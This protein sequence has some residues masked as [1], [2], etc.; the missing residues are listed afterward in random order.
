VELCSLHLAYGADPG[1]LVANS[2][3]A[4]GSASVIVGQGAEGGYGAWQLRDFSSC[5]L[6][7]SRDAMTWSIGDHGFE[8]TLSAGVPEIIRRQLSPWCQS[9][10][11]R[12][13]LEISD[14]RGWAIH[15]GGP[16]ILTAV[17]AALQL[18]PNELRFSR[19]ILARYGN[20]SSATVL[21]ILHQ[22]AAEL[23]GPV[24][25]IGLGPGLMAEGMLLNQTG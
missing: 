9:W 14:I 23:S 24:V 2:L 5:L 16:K 15:P 7:D 11:L 17:A 12:Q 10:L 1:K 18:D 6:P 22:M 4:D 25:G 8:M 21:F 19:D 13:G 20:M 3:F